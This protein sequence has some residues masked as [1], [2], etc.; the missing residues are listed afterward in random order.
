[1]ARF[2]QLDL[3]N[4]DLSQVF[5]QHQF[6]VVNHHASHLVVRNSVED[7]VYDAKNNIIG[8]LN[9]LENCKE[10][11]VRKFI[12]SSSYSVYEETD[13][14]P[15]TETTPTFPVSPY[16]VSKLACEHY[17][18]FYKEV[19]GIDYVIFRYSNVYGPR[20]NPFGEVGVISVF[21]GLML[22]NEDVTIFGDGKAT[23]DYTYISDVIK[24][25]LLA[26]SNLNNTIYNAGTSLETS[27]NELYF[28][29]KKLT[30]SKSGK[31]HIDF[32]KGDAKHN[33]VS[34]EKIKK[35]L[36]WQ[37]KVSLEEGLQKTLDWFKNS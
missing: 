26:L 4:D 21:L 2:Y 19:H 32:K 7:P 18:R 12:F 33:A 10:Y 6:D 35:E 27:I 25:N 14:L 9:T 29:L 1:M 8:L 22:K 30:N 3:A 28:K 23:R 37:P 5:K 16:G 13:N 20:Q 24:T 31:K 15:C 36:G 34:Y 11:N 17:T